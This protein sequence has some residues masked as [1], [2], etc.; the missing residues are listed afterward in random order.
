MTNTTY[1]QSKDSSHPVG[2]ILGIEAD[3]DEHSD[4]F[5]R[6][7]YS[8]PVQLTQWS[9]ASTSDHPVLNQFLENFRHQF[10]SI[11]SDPA[12][13]DSLTMNLENTRLDKADPLELSGP[14]AITEATMA[15]LTSKRGLR[16]Q[17]LSGLSDGG[18]SKL[19]DDVLILPI[20]GFRYVRPLTKHQTLES[21]LLT[22]PFIVQVEAGMG[23]WAPIHTHILTHDFVTMLKAHG[24]IGI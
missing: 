4:S 1:S 17:A 24:D 5:W 18:R 15:Y 7:G 3:T 14:V 19:V 13:L 21:H 9:L 8:Y 2:L 22:S 6:M 23:I 12:D 16:W 20:T 11:V 10:Q